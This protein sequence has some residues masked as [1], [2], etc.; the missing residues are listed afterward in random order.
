MIKK[1]IKF[2]DKIEDRIRA[3]LSHI[4]ILYGIIGGVFAVLFWRGVWHTADI[5]ERWG[6]V[7]GVVFS[8]PGTFILSALALLLS[9]LFVSNFIGNHIIIT[10]LK[11]EK[12][13]IDKTETEISGEE[14]ELVQVRNELK[15][16]QRDLDEIKNKP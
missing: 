9:G 14:S 13:L 15:N 11:K 5:L 7:W 6:G 10:G 16:I 1:L 3:K 8:G 4:P 2:F 12:K